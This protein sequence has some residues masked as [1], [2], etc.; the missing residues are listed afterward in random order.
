MYILLEKN[1]GDRVCWIRNVFPTYQ[2]AEAAM[3]KLMTI[4]IEERAYKIIRKID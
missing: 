2:E 3:N 4:W 1:I